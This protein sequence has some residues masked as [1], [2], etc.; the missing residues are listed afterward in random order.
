MRKLVYWAHR[1][2]FYYVLDR[3]TGKF[4]HGKAFATQTWAKGPE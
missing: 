3:E 4:L 2:G 1:N